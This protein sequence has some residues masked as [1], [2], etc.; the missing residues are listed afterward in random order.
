[1]HQ[2][3]GTFFI[4]FDETCNTSE[5]HNKRCAKKARFT[6]EE[7]ERL[8]QLVAHF[9]LHEWAN[10]ANMM[11]GRNERQV[12]DRYTNFLSPTI[13]K[14]PWT[15]EEDS[16]LRKLLNDFG[17]KWVKIS[18]YFDNRTDVS[19]KTRW[20]TLKRQDARREGTVFKATSHAKAATIIRSVPKPAPKKVPQPF[21][22]LDDIFTS[23]LDDTSAFTDFDLGV[24]F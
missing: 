2:K 17:P 20:M 16:M 15:P 14:A 4:M 21:Q 8:Q 9:G 5:V 6:A 13:N 1:M 23:M 11:P 7:D 3:I 18:S 22:F 10:I 24:T 19:L 12:R